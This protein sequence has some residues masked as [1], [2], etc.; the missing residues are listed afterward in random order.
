METR[1]PWHSVVELPGYVARAAKLMNIEEQAAVIT[2]LAQD[3]E[4]GE[5]MVGTGGVRK[6]R[7]PLAGRGKS[8][9]ARVVYYFHSESI[10]LFLLAVFAKNEKANLSKA[11]RNDLAK[12]VKALADGYRTKR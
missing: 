4:A 10:P 12:L 9:G 6:V 11:E 5:V 8:G 2:A 7:V 3:P 1:R